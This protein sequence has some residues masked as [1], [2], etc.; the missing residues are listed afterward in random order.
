M[1]LPDIIGQDRQRYIDEVRER[2]ATL[3]MVINSDPTVHALTR[4]DA[5]SDITQAV[6]RLG[7]EVESGRRYV[8]P[9]VVHDEA[10]S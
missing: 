1:P 3:I 2:A 10:E 4:E 8:I 9:A 5:V 6:N 7:K